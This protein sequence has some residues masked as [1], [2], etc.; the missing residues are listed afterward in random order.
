MERPT[1]ESRLAG[2]GMY[3]RARLDERI[4]LEAV[5]AVA[6]FS[7]FHFHRVFRVAYGE[8]LNA[9][10]VRHRM[11]R[12]ARELR[13]TDRRVIDIALKCGYESASAFGRAFLR[14][15]E[16]TPSAYRAASER[17]SLVPPRSL[18]LPEELPDPLF[19]DYPERDVLAFHFVGPYDELEPVMYRLYNI[20]VERNFL[21]HG[22]VLGLSYDS[23]DLEDHALLRFDACV[24]PCAGAD[25]S[26]ARADGLV[27]LT[28]SAGRYAVFRHRGA[29]QR[30]T[31]AYDVLFASWVLTGRLEL[32]DA[33]CI[34]TYLS[35]PT[36]DPR[37]LEC[38]LAIPVL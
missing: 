12:A 23:P 13:S 15:F 10:V 5:A 25:V 32:R 8:N 1:V 37:Q 27:P 33:P 34:T 2:A 4:T 7:A 21:P 11:Q 16:M 35:V 28:V 19:V 38:D 18:T 14:A 6:G 31:H 17:M 22:S 26:G 36:G 20:A 24:A 9:Y 3:V 30:I 29:Y